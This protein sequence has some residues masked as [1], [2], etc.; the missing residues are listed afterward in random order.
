MGYRAPDQKAFD[1]AVWLKPELCLNYRLLPTVEELA[2]EA[3]RQSGRDN[4]RQDF[5]ENI[6]FTMG[7]ILA[8]VHRNHIIDHNVYTIIPLKNGFFS[9]TD[10]NPYHINARSLRICTDYLERK[11]YLI[12]KM[13]G[14]Y[15]NIRKFGYPTRYRPSKLLIEMLELIHL[16]NTYDEHTIPI[17][18]NTLDSNPFS[19][20][21]EEMYKVAPLPS[22]RLRDRRENGQK[23]INFNPTEETESTA[24]SVATY[25]SFLREHWVDLLVPDDVLATL[26]G[27]A[28]DDNEHEEKQRYTV[29]DLVLNR[30]LYRVFNNGTF[31]EGGRF[32]GGW[33]Q[34][35]PRQQRQW[36]TID[37]WPTAE[38]DYSSMQ[39]VMLYAKEGIKLEGDAYHID[40]ID[41]HYR[42]LIK[43]TLLKIINA[44]GRMEAPRK[45]ALPEGWTWQQLIEAVKARHEPIAK[46]FRTGIGLQLQRTD[47][48]IAEAVMLE[49][50]SRGKLALPIHDSFVVKLGQ[51]DE[52]GGVMVEEFAR[53]TGQSIGVK[54]DNTWFDYL[55]AT[56][57]EAFELDNHGVRSHEDFWS[58]YESQPQF[59]R[60]RERRSH[61]LKKKG[62]DWIWRHSPFLG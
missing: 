44:T 29:L 3:I 8:N 52:L 5:L 37:W 6:T 41:P 60:Y 18:R 58:D 30:D 21:A 33:W 4:I 35:V 38:V 28:N 27:A 16:N 14:N 50:K 25:N 12:D 9:S 34:N 2:S 55:R 22:I 53:Q 45:D 19:L 36:L 51:Q 61:F 24:A 11:K 40:G 39:I 17:I 23:F 54:G 20:L 48:D 26:Q 59:A 42:P 43:R 57:P 7:V 47:S 32:Y 46:H 49:M 15:D 10:F 31:A 62:E 56:V 1:H 13:G